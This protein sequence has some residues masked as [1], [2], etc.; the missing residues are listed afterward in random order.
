MRKMSVIVA[1][2]GVCGVFL[3]SAMAGAGA[4]RRDGRIDPE[5]GRQLAN[6]PPDRH[7]DHLHLRLEMD[8]ADIEG[9]AFSAVQRL[10][11][12]AIGRE[13][14]RLVLD[15]GPAITVESVRVGGDEQLFE[16]TERGIAIGLRRPIPRGET[17]EVEIR[18]SATAMLEN[19]AGLTWTK[20]DPGGRTAT[21]RAAQI[22]SQGQPQTNS[23]WFP[24]H[25]FPNERMTT[26]LIVTV[27]DGYVVGS[28]GRLVGTRL[29]SPAA[30]G[31]PRTTWHWIQDKPHAA[32]LVSLIVGN[33]SI[34]GLESL[35][36]TDGREVLCYLYTQRG[37][38]AAAAKTYA[39]TSAMLGVF[40]RV[41][42]EPYPWDKYSQALV[43]NFA[44]GGMENTSATTMPEMSAR[45]GKGW[46]DVIAHEAGHQWTGDLIT[47]KSWEHIWLNEG[48]ASFAEAL[49]AEHSA[50]EGRARR[51]YQRK[52]AGF[53]SRQRVM[54]AS[55]APDFPPM[56]SKR[57]G[58]PF[59]AFMRP[60]DAYSKGAIVIHMLR[61]M[62]GDE[63]F[64]RGTRLYVDR[65]R[66]K[67]VETDDF[68][69]CLEEVSGLSLER[70]FKQWCY[71]PGLPRLTVDVEW[72]PDSLDPEQEGAGELAITVRQTQQIDRDNPA[73]A[74]ALPVEIRTGEGR[75]ATSRIIRVEMDTRETRST[76]RLDR[77][78]A[79]VVIDPNL[80]VAAPTRVN[81][82]LAMWQRQLLDHAGE[83]GSVF[84]QLQAVDALAALGKTGTLALVA[85]DPSQD[86]PVRAAAA[87]SLKVHTSNLLAAL[88]VRAAGAGGK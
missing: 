39:S 71:R 34:V 86:E 47:C 49:W 68:R 21:D 22:H 54:N 25:D 16:R 1:V 48:W 10:R 78:P 32:Y 70:F 42:D 72:S 67:E 65:F 80:S 28:N 44:A 2:S 60:N 12:R 61:E 45:A 62:L 82:S 84:A 87:E 88:L 64:L 23:M 30:N 29:G 43:R 53:I 40:E 4:E 37:A 13:R 6:F 36:S 85:A 27:E 73:Y 75:G 50:P 38:E 74:F 7:F 19:G 58:D 81:K 52:I 77:P 51:A 56:V 9:Q 57:Y 8:I 14:S 11:I 3:C 83:G 63:V 55:Y 5:T 35:R 17:A 46:E 79:D 20:G 59:E 41:F 26:E 15:A 66:F 31:R 76:V 18:Y 69:Y 33:F 24:C